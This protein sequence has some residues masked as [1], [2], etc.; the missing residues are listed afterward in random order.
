[1]IVV[2]RRAG[3]AVAAEVVV[4]GSANQ[5]IVVGV[6]RA[7]RAG[8]T[9]LGGEL[10]HHP[11]GKG[12]NQAVAAARWG[13]STAF[14]GALGDDEAGR[15][16]RAVLSEAGIATTG[17]RTVSTA[18]GTALIVVEADGQNRIVVAAGANAAM[19]SLTDSDR[20]A[21]R[22]AR[23]VLAQLEVPPATV[24]AAFRAARTA[25]G[26][27]PRTVLNAS[28]AR[29]LPAG[30]LADTDLLVVN[31]D[32]ARTVTGHGEQPLD[33]VIARLLELVPAVVVTLGAAGCRYRSR[34]GG[35]A[36]V[37]AAKATVVDTTGAGDTFTGVLAACLAAGT[38]ILDGLAAATRAAGVAIG[39]AGAVSSIPTRDAVEAGG[40][41][42][43]G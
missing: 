7:P 43:G 24:S 17:T 6:E 4:V 11:G 16:L 34:D 41:S 42:G 5:D 28:P 8:E 37:P 36:A 35:D 1:M 21:L 22:S 33:A 3:A 39:S 9:V 29:D 23:V 15:G 25:R 19:T 18:T 26:G 14:I 40:A 32:E 31:D 13:A 38:P 30:L 27:G 12:L 20:G 10:S 2:R